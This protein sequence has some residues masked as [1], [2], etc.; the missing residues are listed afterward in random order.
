MSMNTIICGLIWA[1][2]GVES[3]M[4][5]ALLISGFFLAAREKKRVKSTIQVAGDYSLMLSLDG[6]TRDPVRAMECFK[7]LENEVSADSGCLA[8]LTKYMLGHRVRADEMQSLIDV[9]IGRADQGAIRLCGFLAK[10]APLAGLAGTLLGVQ[11]ALSAFSTNRTDPGLIVAGFSTA[12]QTTLAG[13]LV[14]FMCM[15]TSRLL[16]EPRLK[17]TALSIFDMAMGLALR[18]ESVKR[19]AS[20]AVVSGLTTTVK[21]PSQTFQTTVSDSNQSCHEETS[22]QPGGENRQAGAERKGQP[23]LVCDHKLENQTL[24]QNAHDAAPI[25]SEVDLVSQMS[26]F[27][28]GDIA[29][30]ACKLPPGVY[31]NK[32]VT[33]VTDHV[34]L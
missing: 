12:L 24:Q 29:C 3:V 34:S 27:E 30:T 6:A 25:E 23:K 5:L 9:E 26:A 4:A 22:S 18:I 10:T 14:A 15:G 17:R 7:D 33:E 16:I 28:S 11:A 13:V 1:I 20:K 32:S 19:L 2:L 8:G 21:A 31:R